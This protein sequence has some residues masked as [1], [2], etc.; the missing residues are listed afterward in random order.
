MAMTA[1]ILIRLV[2]RVSGNKTQMYSELSVWGG[3]HW[4]AFKKLHILCPKQ[5]L[6]CVFIMAGF[7]PFEARH[8]FYIKN[9]ETNGHSLEGEFLYAMRAPRIFFPWLE[10]SFF[11]HGG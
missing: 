9:K 10:F 8:G 3:I 6:D 5:K 1:S 7:N 11:A 2:S 4:S